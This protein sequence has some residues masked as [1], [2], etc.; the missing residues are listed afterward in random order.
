M[1]KYYARIWIDLEVNLF[2]SNFFLC[3][4]KS[5]EIDNPKLPTIS[6]SIIK[7]K[8]FHILGHPIVAPVYFFKCRPAAIIT[9]HAYLQF[10]E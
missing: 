1:I 3:Q 10:L 2:F 6:M 5:N 4:T 7:R 9:T 8:Y